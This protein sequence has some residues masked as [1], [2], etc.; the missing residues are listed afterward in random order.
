MCNMKW[1]VVALLV[2]TVFKAA[3]HFPC[4]CEN[5]QNNNS[6]MLQGPPGKL[7]PPG[8]PGDV[9]QC[10]CNTSEILEQL[11]NLSNIVSSF[12]GII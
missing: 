9:I 8:P 10:G 3:A 6:N 1:K 7:G 11:R 2:F 5:E 4:I 12:K